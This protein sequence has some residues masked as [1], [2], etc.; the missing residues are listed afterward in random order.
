M[1]FLRNFFEVRFKG[2]SKFKNPKFLLN[3]R[4]N[5]RDNYGSATLNYVS[6]FE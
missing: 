1:K 3:L 6:G 5:I 2:T 4:E